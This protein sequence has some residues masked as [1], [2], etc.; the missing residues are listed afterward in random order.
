MEACFTRS[1]LTSYLFHALYNSTEEMN[2]HYIETITNQMSPLHN[3]NWTIREG[4]ITIQSHKLNIKSNCSH[5]KNYW[6]ECVFSTMFLQLYL[7]KQHCLLKWAK[8]CNL[9]GKP[10]ILYFIKY[11]TQLFWIHVFMDPKKDPKIYWFLEYRGFWELSLYFLECISTCKKLISSPVLTSFQ[12][13]LKNHQHTQKSIQG[14]YP[15]GT[16]L[17]QK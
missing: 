7:N 9:W 12:G 14:H 3:S 10:P 16:L 4:S 5:V 15:K 1:H 11:I 8:S 2:I 6:K 13:A 17:T